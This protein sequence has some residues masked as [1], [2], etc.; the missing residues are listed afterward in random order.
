MI[1]NLSNIK[2]EGFKSIKSLDLK[3]KPINVLIGAN[4]S[5]KTNFITVFQFLNI[6]FQRKLQNYVAKNGGAERFLHFG[7][8]TTEKIFLKLSF[9]QDETRQNIMKLNWQKIQKMMFY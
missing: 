9:Y 4:G 6:I 8:K 7:S 5:G 2:I 1:Q 3:M